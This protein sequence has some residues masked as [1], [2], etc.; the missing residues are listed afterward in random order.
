[1][2]ILLVNDYKEKIAG[3]EMYMWSL[4]EELEKKG[5]IVE[6]F[7]SDKSKEQYVISLKSKSIMKYLVRIFNVQAYLTFNKVVKEFNP[8][9][10]HIQGIF[11]ELSPSILLVKTH[12]PIIMTVHNNQI[13]NA[14]SILSERTGKMCKK[15]TCG[16]CINCVGIKGAIYEYIKRNI[17]KQLLKKVNLY[18][19]PSKY[20]MGFVLE[21]GFSPVITIPNGIKPF[22]YKKIKNFNRILFVGRLTKDKGVDYLLNAMPRVLRK[23]P[24]IKL[25]IV[26]D[27]VDKNDFV[28]LVKKL[29]ISNSVEFVGSV[30]DKT[31]RNY[32]DEASVLVVP[33]VW[34]EPFGLIGI[35]AMSTGRPVIG[36][37]VGGI[38]EWLTDSET[39]YLIT[40]RSSEEIST[41]ILK[42]LSNESLLKNMGENSRNVSERFTIEENVRKLEM[43]YNDLIK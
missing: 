4:K 34:N 3:A 41:R 28:F 17:H 38:P 12:A 23:L 32:Y 33:S 24:D 5:H 2:K 39:G 36:S 15:E 16:G 10:I 30:E 9:I 26:G 43:A 37:K 13:V 1:M 35:E 18:I 8:D 40:P 25:Q 7:G 42:L 19:T 14:V 11:N 29:G 31:I 20:M 27:G 6:V 21:A 22:K